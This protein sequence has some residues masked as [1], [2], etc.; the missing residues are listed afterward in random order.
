M[1]ICPRF[2]LIAICIPLRNKDELIATD[3][4]QVELLRGYRTQILTV[5]G[6]D[7]DHARNTLV[8][9]ALNIDADYIF[10]LDNDVL[11]QPDTLN[12]LIEDLEYLQKIDP[13]IIAV[14]GDYYTKGEDTNSVHT[15][16][17]ED[18]IV[19]EVNRTRLF[20]E[21]DYI[22]INWTVGFGCILIDTKI[23][24][25]IR[26]PWFYSNIYDQR[27]KEKITEDAWFTELTLFAG[28]KIIL[29]KNVQ[30]LHIDFANKKNCLQSL[31]I[32][33]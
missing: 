17:D 12:R 15:I 33:G 10:F 28:Y 30:C 21:K 4:T 5:Y 20:N 26:Y 8:Q 23:F 27:T 16:V 25:Q 32:R 13:S 22:Q 29:D 6:M 9:Q 7:A 18:G 19:K 3:L 11:I 2:P 1:R 14:T 24:K 31:F